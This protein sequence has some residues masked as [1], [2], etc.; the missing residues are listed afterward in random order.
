M[1]TTVRGITYQGD[2][3]TLYAI[4][5]KTND[6]TVW[7]GSSMATWANGSITTYKLALTAQSGDL[8]TFTVPTTLPAGAWYRFS[9]YEQAGASAAITDLLLATEELYWDGGTATSFGSG[10]YLTTLAN[11]KLYAGETGTSNDTKYTNA[12]AAASV[13]IQNW[14]D[15][16]FL[17]GTYT[18]YHDGPKEVIT[19]RNRPI[20]AVTRIA[21]S[22]QSALTIQNSGTSVG[23]ATVATTSTSLTLSSTAS[24]TTTTTT[25]LYSGS[26]TITALA[27]AINAVSGWA[28]TADTSLGKFNSTDLPSPI[29]VSASAL[30]G[31][32]ELEVYADELYRTRINYERGVIFGCFPEGYRSVEVKYTAGSATV[33]EPFSRRARHSPRRCT[34][35]AT[36][37]HSFSP[38][39]SGITPIRRASR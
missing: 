19:L 14:C 9:Y 35:R 7:D 13:F 36:P 31:P 23:R 4:I 16:D 1:S 26:T 27:A 25:I 18:E 17:V 8:Y 15:Q 34:A 33:P 3:A 38:S 5:R 32:A 22:P 21:T 37:I 2:T 11:V 39:V 20:T 12:L 6:G 24:G 28:A 30:D 10:T 29:T